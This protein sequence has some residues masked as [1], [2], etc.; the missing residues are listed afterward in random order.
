VSKINTVAIIGGGVS[1]LS[2]GGLLSRKGLRVKLFEA[3]EKLGGCCANTNLAGYT[4]ND[5]ALY[6]VLPGILDHVFEKLGLDRPSL[7]P[8]RKIT[9]NETATLPDGTVVSIADRLDVSVKKSHGDTDGI[10]LQKELGSMLKKWEPVLH[11]FA[12]DI[13]IHPFS[14]S[15]L[16]VK[17]WRHLHKFRG[18]VASEINKLFSDEAVRAAMSGV[19]LYTGLPPQKTPVLQI[20]GLVA[21][22]SEG[23]YLPEGGMGK[24]PEAL[25]L[26][27]KKNGGELFLNARI[28]KIIVKNGRVYGL[29]VDGQGLVEVDAV[30]S[31]ISGMAT[32]DILL[33]PEDIPYDMR[34]KVQNTALS[35]KALGLQLGLSNV[36]GPCSHSNSILPMMEEQYKLFIL[37]EDDVNWFNYTVPT[38]TMPDLAPRG[39]SIIEMFLPVKQNLPVDDWDEQKKEKIVASAV[40]ALSRVHDIHI[41][42][43]RALSPKD[44]RDRMH[45]YKGALYG[46]SPAVDPRALFPHNPPI[47]GLYQAGQTTYPGY[48]VGP[49][50]MSGIFA[51]EAL[52]KTKNM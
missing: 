22:L 47:L 34:G 16:M 3:N 18:T 1:G 11:L 31:T 52:M 2:A 28:H 41:A 38:I 4:F 36:V 44:F 25:T 49:A 29:E 12:E 43:K 35:H 26:S 27:L 21:M 32:F 13:I 23:L 45:F 33:N 10:K 8:L 51:A 6:L 42:V 7:L 24:I 5:G 46:L 37:D 17:G 39:G 15:R 20:L 48:G 40:R 30:I 19:L 9:S 50:A 14:L